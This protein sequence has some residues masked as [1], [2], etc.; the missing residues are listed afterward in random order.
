V[1]LLWFLQ[2]QSVCHDYHRYGNLGR[3]ATEPRSEL[4]APK[5]QALSE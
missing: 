5:Q 4:A 3:R 2:E 1:E